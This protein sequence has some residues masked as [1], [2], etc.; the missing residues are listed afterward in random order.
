MLGKKVCPV[1]LAL[2]GHTKRNLALFVMEK[3]VF[4][5]LSYILYGMWGRDRDRD[6]E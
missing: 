2:M 3:E 6:K 4:C 1:Q 5:D